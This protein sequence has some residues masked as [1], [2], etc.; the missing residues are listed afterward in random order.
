MN[1]GLI[2]RKHINV[3]KYSLKHYWSVTS[4]LKKTFKG[5]LSLYITCPRQSLLW[6]FLPVNP[7]EAS[8]AI[9]RFEIPALLCIA[10][11][12]LTRAVL[13]DQCFAKSLCSGQKVLHREEKGF[14]FP[15]MLDWLRGN[16]QLSIHRGRYSRGQGWGR[17]TVLVQFYIFCKSE[18]MLSVI[19]KCNQC[20]YIKV[21]LNP[22]KTCNRL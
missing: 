10:L 22:W 20:N 2:W 9:R 3:T 14:L 7:Q 5:E 17:Y 12:G 4:S 15:N 6:W 21:S 13:I 18:L 11:S 1:S 19:L 16:W 8:W